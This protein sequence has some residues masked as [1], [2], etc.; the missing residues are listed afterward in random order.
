MRFLVVLEVPRILNKHLSIPICFVFSS[1]PSFTSKDSFTTWFCQLHSLRNVYYEEINREYMSVSLTI[2][3][4]NSWLYP[5]YNKQVVFNYSLWIDKSSGVGKSNVNPTGTWDPSHIFF[6]P[7]SLIH[8]FIVG[9]FLLFIFV[10]L[11]HS[12]FY[13]IPRYV[14]VINTGMETLQYTGINKWSWDRGIRLRWFHLLQ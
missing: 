11:V 1:T 6:F 13:D 5:N 9:L 14:E 10:M 3:R 2:H 4:K 12:R 7:D 8:E